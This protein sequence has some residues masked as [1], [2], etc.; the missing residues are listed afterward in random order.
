[1]LAAHC[2]IT[3]NL[4]ECGS[5]KQSLYNKRLVQH[6][7]IFTSWHHVVVA[8]TVVDICMVVENYILEFQRVLQ[9]ASDCLMQNL[10][11]PSGRYSWTSEPKRFHHTLCRQPCS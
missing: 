5:E 11:E 1:M 2:D 8:V 3:L 10:T 4:G 6:N 9:R 7:Y